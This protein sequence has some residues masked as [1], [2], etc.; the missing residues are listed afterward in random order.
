MM[1]KE[2][3]RKHLNIDKELVIVL[4]LVSITGMAYALIITQL[5]VLNLYYLNLFYI[6]V[7][8][9]A[10][11]FGKKH[12][13]Y[14]AVLSVVIISATAY[15]IPETFAYGNT[16][17]TASMKWVEIATWGGLLIVTGYLMGVLY[18]KKAQSVRRVI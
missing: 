2:G 3:L 8:F 10:Y 7:L 1:I 5:V 16:Y 11:F 9:W 17:D 14:S 15:F 18:E 12:G 13:T 4:L 6:P